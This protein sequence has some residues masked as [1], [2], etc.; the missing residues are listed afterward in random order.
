VFVLILL[1]VMT[2]TARI[3]YGYNA[4]QMPA[5]FST[6]FSLP[7]GGKRYQV[8]QGSDLQAAIDR[9]ALGD[10]IVLDA[11][12]TFIGNF[13][14]PIKA[15][16]GWIYIISSELNDLPEGSRVQPADAIHMPKIIPIQNGNLPALMPYKGAHHYRFAGIEFL[17]ASSGSITGIYNIIQMGYGSAN[18]SDGV[19]RWTPVKSDADLPSYITFDRCYFHSLNVKPKF[20]RCAIMANGHYIAIIDSYISGI[21]DTSDAQ[22]I[23]IWNGGGPYKIVNNYLEASG[24]NFMSGGTDP[25]IANAVPSDIEFRGNYCYK[26]NSWDGLWTIK[27]LFELKNA[28]RVLVTGNVFENCFKAMGGQGATALVLTVRNQSG[29]APWSVVQD[30]TITNNKIRSCGRGFN[31]TGEDD[32]HPSQQTKRILIQNNVID[33]LSQTYAGSS[34]GFNLASVNLPLLDLTMRHNLILHTDVGNSLMFLSAGQPDK[35]AA[36]NFIFENNIVTHAKYG[37]FGNAVGTGTVAL[38]RFAP[39]N[40]SWQRN[41]VI[42][43]TIDGD[44]TYC[45]ASFAKLYPSNNSAADGL[46][47]I[48]FTDFNNR[49]YRLSSRSAYKNKGT[50]GKDPGPDWDLLDGATAHAKDGKPI[51]MPKNLTIAR[52]IPLPTVHIF[53]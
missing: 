24:E 6:S 38:T 28:Q 53:M 31:L 18:Y 50:D 30:V 19:Y 10:I 48:G 27:N 43:R 34:T 51:S 42:M 14:L 44:Y 4:P 49:N 12:A 2:G 8:A 29:G 20:C 17:A 5:T 16:T 35:R 33:D 15:G 40:Y 36:E 39:L 46:A 21:T 37:M 26:Q 11:R 41:V 25:S 45:L 13:K 3:A 9:A 22:A 32:L 1:I 7:Q 52:I 47:A 23:W